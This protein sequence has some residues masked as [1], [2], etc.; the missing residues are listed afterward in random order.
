MNVSNLV[1]RFPSPPH[2]PTFWLLDGRTGWQDADLDHVEVTARGQC[3]SLSPQPGSGR[4][5]GE[6]SG[7]F[8]G[9]KLPANVALGPDGSV[10]L[11]DRERALLKRFDPCQCEFEV[12]PCLAGAGSGARQLNN[13]NGIAICGS[14]LFVC[15]NGNHRLSVFSLRGFVLRAHWSPPASAALTNAWQPFALAFDGRGR[16]FVSDPANGC[17]H[18]FHPS[19]KWEKSLPGFGQVTHIAIDCHDHLHVLEQGNP[20]EVRTVDVEG[21]D[22]GTS[23]RVE[24][25]V[26]LLPRPPFPVDSAGNLHLTSLCVVHGPVSD[27]V[28]D[29]SGEPTTAQT[30]TGPIYSPNGI[31]LSRPLDSKFYRCQWHRIVLRGCVPVGSQVVVETY[32]A[33]AEE[34]EEQIKNLADDVWETQQTVKA[35]TGGE[36]DCLVRSGGGRFL[37]L[38]LR[39]KSKGAV[40]PL[41]E[42]VRVEFPRITS[43]RFLPAVFGA[44]PISADFTDRFL[45]IFDTTLRGIEQRVDQQAGLFD[46]NSAPAGKGNSGRL[47]FLSWLG[48]WI[49]ITL[50][51]HWPEARRRNLLK[52]A[53]GLYSLRGTREGLWRQLLILLDLDPGR[54]CCADDG[55]RKQCLPTPANCQPT[56]KKSCAWQPPPLILEH[57][58]LRRWLFLDS[59]RLGDQAVLWGKRIMNRSQLNDGAQLDRTRLLTIQDPYRDPFHYY[60][61][62]FTVFVP[63]AIEKS[64]G[65]RKALE[66]LLQSQRP[67]HTVSHVEFVGPRFRIGVQSMIGLDSVV[68]RYPE[69]VTLNQSALGGASVLTA[70]PYKQGGPSLEI[71]Q[72]SRIG[73]TTKLE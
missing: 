58:Q 52:Q 17:I 21:Q 6:T 47:D 46:P 42:N 40:T 45:S 9:A 71:G 10:Y 30:A 48:T 69:G 15:D 68:G 14:N 51:R 4:S 28:F 5:L 22:I 7:S 23:S 54:L 13:A 72:R 59:G 57:F 8:G 66:N 27:A 24:D 12:V 61:H 43:R 16:A 31:Y 39:F 67:A 20:N 35:I 29:L 26:L 19:G 65:Q 53:A 56:E 32:T 60:A 73:T 3:L 44:E 37:W 36:W 63:A 64:E 49:G 55:P 2:D 25:L 62:K 33:E 50:D 11:L 34:T 18:R 38:R 70:P 1:Q 41:I